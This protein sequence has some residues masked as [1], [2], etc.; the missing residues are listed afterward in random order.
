MLLGYNIFMHIYHVLFDKIVN[1]NVLQ[2][3]RNYV[4][5][6]ITSTIKM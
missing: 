1:R 4:Y 3:A 5:S 2:D 6:N